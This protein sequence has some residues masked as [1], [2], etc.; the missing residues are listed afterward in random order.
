MIS[1]IELLKQSTKSGVPIL[2]L[3]TKYG[4]LFVQ[5]WELNLNYCPICMILSVKV[6]VIRRRAI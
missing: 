3:C 1:G 5:F 4:M 6:A 2:E